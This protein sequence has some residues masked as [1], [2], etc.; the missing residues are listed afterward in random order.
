MR[1]KNMIVVNFIFT[2]AFVMGS[3][4]VV[5][6]QSGSHVVSSK[7][8]VSISATGPE[9]TS[10]G[11]GFVWK[12]S[13]YVVTALHV[14]AGAKQI[15]VYSETQKAGTSADLAAVIMEA[16]L[17]LL[18]L[19]DDLGLTPL[20]ETAVS[21]NSTAEFY[22]WGYP[23]NVAKMQGDFIRFS[24]S[25]TQTPTMKSIFKSASQ[26]RKI[27]GDQ[28]YPTFKA[29]ILRIST[30]IQPGHSGA[31]ILD[32]S[33]KVV[34]IGDGGLRQGIARINWA[35]PASVYLPH[36]E[37]SRDAPPSTTSRQTR[38]FGKR[39][40]E[41][42]KVMT[43]G[44]STLEKVWTASLQEVL[45]TADPEL[46]EMFNDISQE[47]LEE[48]GKNLGDAWIDVYEDSQTGA[49]I[50][51]PRDF[52]VQ[53]HP[54]NGLLIT[55]YPGKG[56]LAMIIQILMKDSFDQGMKALRA[57]EEVLHNL[58]SWRTD[59]EIPDDEDFDPT[60]S[61]LVIS[62]FRY[63]PDENNEATDE[64]NL[65]LVIDRNDFLGAAVVARNMADFDEEAWYQ[66]YVMHMCSE[67]A[68]F[69]ID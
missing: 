67:L 20:Q 45:S 46:V 55:E 29:R 69:P 66:L 63:V 36:L 35:I 1:I 22:I 37:N 21:P 2:V 4:G 13:T 39:V 56:N 12:K 68:D 41:K 5:S 18:Q 6:A 11:S 34:G 26:F 51:V 59:P 64:M 38:L 19:K 7:S 25:Q 23:H 16:D 42:V 60:D 49:T 65:S 32:K 14:V 50:A 8:V 43:L 27:V 58:T 40:E 28:G 3:W 54:D 10:V 24:L 48:T 9:G 15:E 62:Q 57:Y 53:Y 61:S 44:N 52:P 33:G 17:A 30:T 31:P 47:A